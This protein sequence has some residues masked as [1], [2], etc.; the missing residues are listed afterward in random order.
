MFCVPPHSLLFS[1][2]FKAKFLDIIIGMTHIAFK[3]IS[4]YKLHNRF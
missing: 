3:I 2:H 4:D 1:L